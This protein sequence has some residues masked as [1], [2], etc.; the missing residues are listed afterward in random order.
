MLAYGSKRHVAQRRLYAPVAQWIRASVFGTEGRT[1][2]SYRVYQEN[3]PYRKT[4]GGFSCRNN[5]F[6]AE[7][8][9]LR[10]NRLHT[11]DI[12][13]NIP[14]RNYTTMKLGGPA[15]FMVEVKSADDIPLICKNA[16][17]QNLPIAILGG[18][19][20]TIV[21][22][23]GFSGIILHMKIP[24]IEIV[25]DDLYSTTLRIGAG[26]PWDSVVAYSVER[27]L[28]GIEAMS[29]IPGTTGAAPVQNVGAYGQETA[30]TLVSL[31]AYDKS[32]DT[33]VTLTNEECG[34]SYRS[35]IFRT[36][37]QGRYIITSVTLKLSKNLPAP[38][39]YDALQKYL[40]DA[41]ITTYT[42]A[43]IRDAVIAIRASKLPDPSFVANTGSFFKNAIVEAWQL[44]DL[45]SQ[46]P[47]IPSYDMGDGTFK[48]PSGGLIETAGFKGK[49]L[50]GM[51]V[52]EKNALVL[53]NE[54]AQT[55]QDLADARDEIIGTIR[56][57]FRIL[58]EQEPLELHS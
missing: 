32:N 18:G 26:E 33:F 7:E 37:E 49:L 22:D 47:N 38:P 8:T 1:F 50:H 12:H 51:R 27:R 40:D 25:T 41:N 35:S 39:F 9:D 53:V 31:N 5:W 24:G 42:H 14:L 11:M 21:R 29:A 52:Y 2:E 57:T 20:N 4:I 58:I 15:R 23:E 43:V 3:P 17:Q 19:S 16:A 46:Y 45:Q 13:T 6:I 28:S 54:S 44:R 36:T 10:Y 55:Y 34:F 56:D 48:I 30:D